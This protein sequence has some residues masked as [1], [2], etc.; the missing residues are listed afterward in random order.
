MQFKKFLNQIQ[1][2]SKKNFTKFKKSFFKTFKFYFAK[3][4]NTK[5]Y[6]ILNKF[7]K[8]IIF[9][10]LFFA[11]F[12]NL[13]FAQ[14]NIV[15]QV[16]NLLQ[17]KALPWELS[18]KN[19]DFLLNADI[20]NFN[21]EPKIKEIKQAESGGFYALI[22]I[23]TISIKDNLFQLTEK[24][25]K[26]TI[27][28]SLYKDEDGL[29]E[30]VK[31][32]IKDILDGERI[33]LQGMKEKLQN[34]DKNLLAGLNNAL[35]GLAINDIQEELPP[36][37]NVLPT[38]TAGEEIDKK[39]LFVETGFDVNGNPIYTP[40]G[41]KTT[42]TFDE[43]GIKNFTG[44]VSIKPDPNAIPQNTDTQNPSN[45][46]NSATTT[47]QTSQEKEDEKEV[48]KIVEEAKKETEEI[49]QETKP[50]E[51]PTTETPKEEV[52]TDTV[53]STNTE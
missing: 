36:Q 42:V 33:Y 18:V 37:A 40:T 25:A 4:Q 11:L 28:E 15:S 34:K 30:F 26:V 35:K 41:I 38:Q 24:E 45:N 27:A 1:K 5:H 12:L 6:E 21:F 39:V 17:E 51:T 16:A 31:K 9:G 23:K 22:T 7:K 10:I 52:K 47:E 8:S 53:N 14:N 3:F 2:V 32:E 13:T 43:N 50:A 48:E 46:Q 19:P 29:S 49:I 20:E 44:A